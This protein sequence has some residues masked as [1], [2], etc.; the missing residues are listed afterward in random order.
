DAAASPTQAA[1]TVLH[2]IMHSDILNEAILATRTGKTIFP[3]R[4]FFGALGD[5]LS[6]D[7]AFAL[8]SGLNFYFRAAMDEDVKM[9]LG[10]EVSRLY[11]QFAQKH[12]LEPEHISQLSPLLARLMSTKLE[13][14]RFESVD[15]TGVFD[16]SVHE[17]TP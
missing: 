17:R 7:T 1:N 5:A 12:S 8:A 11:Y 2:R 4:V 14:L 15:S 3:R 9:Q 13:Q 10:I 6:D 16:S